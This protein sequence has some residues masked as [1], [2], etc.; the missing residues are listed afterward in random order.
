MS[1]VYDLLDLM[2]APAWLNIP[3]AGIEDD[4]Y[5]FPTLEDAA[6]LALSRRPVS[7]TWENRL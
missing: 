5:D 2:E 3:P 1:D 4:F 6:Y 7:L